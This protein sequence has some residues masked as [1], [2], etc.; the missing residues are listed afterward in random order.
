MERT[1]DLSMTVYVSADKD[2]EGIINR[3][4]DKWADAGVPEGSGI[5]VSWDEVT[6]DSPDL[7]V[8]TCDTCKASYD[9]ASRDGRCGDCG[10]CGECCEDVF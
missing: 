1:Y 4:L 7:E 8:G 5:D 10:N 3:L 6:W 2:H 9:L